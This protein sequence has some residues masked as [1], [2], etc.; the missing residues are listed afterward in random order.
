MHLTRSQTGRHMPIPRKGTTYVARASGYLDTGI[1][2][3]VAIR[4]VLK[5]AKTSREVKQLIHEG[6]LSINGR[7]VKDFKEA[8]K[9][10]G[11][12]EADKK[13]KLTVLPTGRYSFEETKD[14]FR[15]CKVI[16]KK[17]LKG[18]TIQINL[19]DGTNFLSKE[20]VSIGDSVEIGLDGKVKKIV[21][22]E[23]G[24]NVFVISGNKMGV[25]GKIVEIKDGKF[26]LKTE[27]GESELDKSHAF[28]I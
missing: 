12:F 28:V 1:P 22:F 20:K 3:V 4:D 9:F 10:F 15:V 26:T 17:M 24:K 13:Y 23:K 5:L 18:K 7:K 6:L 11:I 27:D 2:V 25:K 14:D 21:H 16:G 8:I 19:H